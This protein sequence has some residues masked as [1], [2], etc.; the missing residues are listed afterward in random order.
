MEWM[1]HKATL[2]R[3]SLI[4]GELVLPLGTKKQKRE[5]TQINFNKLKTLK[6]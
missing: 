1:A 4:Q 5:E 2:L 6:Q 3:Y